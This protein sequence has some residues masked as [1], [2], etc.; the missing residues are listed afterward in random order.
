MKLKRD[1]YTLSGGLL[2]MDINLIITPWDSKVFGIDTFEI[3]HVSEEIL[4]QVLKI[5]GHFTVKV[6][7]LSSKKLLHDYC[8]YYCDTLIEPY[9]SAERFIFYEHDKISISKNIVVDDLINISHGAFTHGRFHRDFN[10][11]K[12]LSDVRY[13]NWLRELNDKGNCFGLIYEE[14][15]AGFL[16]VNENKIV[17]HALS[18]KYK[19]KGL[20]KYFWSIACKE[21]FDFGFTEIESSI[22]A[23][24]IPVLNLYASLGFRFRNPCDIYHKLNL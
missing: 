8:F 13:D 5:P 6:D 12:Q 2:K 23:A 1:L 10:L 19:G 20:A 15:V 9:C 7:P 16:G 3:K 22:S 21:L 18:N 11:D 24:N 17:L 4:N 14:E